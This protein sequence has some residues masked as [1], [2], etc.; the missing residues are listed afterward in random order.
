VRHVGKSEVTTL[1][2]NA[3]AVYPF[4]RLPRAYIDEIGKVAEIFE[5]HDRKKASNPCSFL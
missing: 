1:N 3:G 2:A 4:I 5:I